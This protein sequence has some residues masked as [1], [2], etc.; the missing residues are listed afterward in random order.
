[1]FNLTPTV[2]IILFINIGVYLLQT[3]LGP[4]LDFIALFPVFSELFKPWQFLTYMFAH[5]GFMHILFNMFGLISFGPLLEQR[6]GGNRFL[7]FWLVCGI[8]AGVLYSGVRYYELKKMNESRIEFINEPSGGNFADFFR[9]NAPEARGYEV[10]ATA[11]QRNAQDQGLVASAT[12]SVNAVYERSVNSPMVGA[13]GALFGILFAFA[14]L[15]P[16]TELIM[17]FL[18][19]PIKAKYLVFFYALF[20][21]YSGVHRTPGDNVAHFAHLGGMLIGF[22]LLKFWEHSRTR[23]Y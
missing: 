19:I 21:L 14:Y 10:V 3:Q 5:G 4:R 16:N 15:F 17:L 2:R 8:G 22:L 12:E 1:M 11:L 18:P 9:A 7:T 20:E 23:F 13:S 6:W